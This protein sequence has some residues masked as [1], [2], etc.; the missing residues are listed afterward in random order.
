VCGLLV[1]IIAAGEC[2]IHFNKSKNADSKE[3]EITMGVEMINILIVT[4]KKQLNQHIL[5][6]IL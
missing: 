3:K 4:N 1:I 2:F 6:V 5:K